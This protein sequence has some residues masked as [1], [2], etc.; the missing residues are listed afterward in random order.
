M[1]KME[2]MKHQIQREEI[3]K[4]DFEDMLTMKEAVELTGIGKRKLLEYMNSEILPYY[5]IPK[6]NRRFVKRADVMNLFQKAA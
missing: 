5:R 3:S 2:M 4:E 6:S 1:Q